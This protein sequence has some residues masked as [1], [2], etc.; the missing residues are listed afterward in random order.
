MKLSDSFRCLRQLW[1][2]QQDVPALI[3]ADELMLR[4][5]RQIGRLLNGLSQS[6]RQ[7]VLQAQDGRLMATGDL[8]TYGLHGLAVRIHED[9]LLSALALSETALLRINISAA[10]EAGVLMFSLHGARIIGNW[11]VA[12]KLPTELL[13]M[14]SRRHFRLCGKGSLGLLQHASIS[15]PGLAQTLALRDLS[16]E[17]AGL[18]LLAQEWQGPTDLKQARLHL[19]QVDLPIPLLQVVHK[20]LL[21]AAAANCCTVGARLVGIQP[22]HIRSLRRWLLATQAEM[23]LPSLD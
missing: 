10:S 14:Q 23:G 9:C 1:Q 17:G 19:G 8:Q 6:R 5:E 3:S 15:C 13:R 21:S 18:L 11:L 16:E 20:R 7:V 4:D 22:E 12:A 2:S